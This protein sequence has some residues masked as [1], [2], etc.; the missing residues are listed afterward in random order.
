MTTPLII[1]E[2]TRALH[3][4]HPDQAFAEYILNG[5][6]HGFRIGFNRK[7]RLSSASANMQSAMLHPQVI[8]EYLQKEISLERMI[9][10][11]PQ[12]A[13]ISSLLHI[14]RFGVIPKGHNTGKWRLI[15]DLSHPAGKS[16]N[17]GID[18]EFCSLSY[19][20][21]DHAARVISRLGRGSLLAKISSV[22]AS[23]SPP[24]RPRLASSK[25]GG[26]TLCR[27]DA[28]IRPSL[29][30]QDLQCDCGRVSMALTATRN[31]TPPS[32]LG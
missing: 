12:G 8:T 18:P 21:V 11:I 7:S 25:V 29:S 27:S 24:M 13:A 32:L 30:A 14:N 5:L 6:K 15:T 4:R 22:Q 23:T 28:A 17:D 9:G 16:V 20:S 31:Q 26:E 3:H 10:P 19:I 2:W 1:E